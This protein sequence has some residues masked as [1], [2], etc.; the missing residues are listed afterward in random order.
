MHT[1]PDPVANGVQGV[2]DTFV[3]VYFVYWESAKNRTDG[4]GSVASVRL[5]APTKSL[6]SLRVEDP[7]Y[8]LRKPLVF[9]NLYDLLAQTN[10]DKQTRSGRDLTPSKNR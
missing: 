8:N 2:K 3:P 9:T 1:A 5:F 7:K 10:S 4:Y 6:M